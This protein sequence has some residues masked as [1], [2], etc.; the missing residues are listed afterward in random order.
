MRSFALSALACLLLIV[1]AGA[2]SYAQGVDRGS[3]AATA[4]LDAGVMLP[5]AGGVAPSKAD[6][7]D[8]IADPAGAWQE[9]QDARKTG[10]LQIALGVL[11][12][13]VAGSI[14][15]K[16]QPI[17]GQ[18]EPDPESWRARSIALLGA[19]AMV[20]WG[21]ADRAAGATSWIGLATIAVAA[22]AL[23]WR[24][25]D[26]PRGSADKKKTTTATA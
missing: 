10:G 20:A 17:P 18:P 21:V 9:F 25:V 22:G 8:P 24:A 13:V 14:R 11:V 4:E 3:A 5:D 26:P 6:H 23:V 12:A 19:A 7:A 1:I 2:V 15:R 16:L